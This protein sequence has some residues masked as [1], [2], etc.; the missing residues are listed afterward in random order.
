MRLAEELE[1]IRRGTFRQERVCPTCEGVTPPL[2]ADCRDRRGDV[3]G[4]HRIDEAKSLTD[5]LGQL[6]VYPPMG[7]SE[8]ERDKDRLLNRRV[9]PKETVYGRLTGRRRHDHM[10]DPGLRPERSLKLEGDLVETAKAQSV[11]GGEPRLCKWWVEGDGSRFQDAER[12]CDYGVRSRH[13][14]AVSET[15]ENAVVLDRDGGDLRV[16]PDVKA[17][18]ER[19]YELAVPANGDVAHGGT[20]ELEPVGREP[21]HRDVLP[22][23]GRVCL[24]EEPDEC[25]DAMTLL[26]IETRHCGASSRSGCTVAGGMFKRARLNELAQNGLSSLVQRLELACTENCPSVRVPSRCAVEGL[27]RNL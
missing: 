19:V 4:H 10:V 8:G 6:V 3:T 1:I 25:S 20:L 21:R 18:C 24:N 7:R 12:D 22:R 16:E 23:A 27:P 13:R 9:E 14:R 15:D 26:V 17:V 2:A 5:Q 11:D